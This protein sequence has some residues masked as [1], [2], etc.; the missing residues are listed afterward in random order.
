MQYSLHNGTFL[1]STST[2]EFWYLGPTLP[3]AKQSDLA[4]KFY[5]PPQ[6]CASQR[7]SF[8]QTN[9]CWC[10]SEHCEFVLVPKDSSYCKSKVKKRQIN[11]CG[12][13]TADIPCI[14]YGNDAVLPQKGPILCLCLTLLQSCHKCSRKVCP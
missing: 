7:V 9:K 5:T 14:L 11:F 4:R 6:S 13:M 3:E 10:W 8:A 1:I 12:Q 2:F